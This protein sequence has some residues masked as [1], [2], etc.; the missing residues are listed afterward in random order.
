M[1]TVTKDQLVKD[2]ISLGV[3]KGELLN[4]KASLK[5]IGYVEGGADTLIEALLTVVGSEGTIITDSFVSVFSL[6]RVIS[7]KNLI[8]DDSTE[9]YAGALA[10]AML[11]HPNV[12]RSQHPVQKFS[13]IGFRAKELMYDHD[14]ESYAYNVL[15]VLTE[16]DGR[17]LKIG[18][19]E[20]V[21]GVGTT[22]LA[23]GL[24]KYKQKR[25]IRGVN[26]KNKMGD[27]TVFE[28]NWAGGCGKGFNNFIP[29]YEEN[30]AII[31]K[32]KI[33]LADSKITDMKMTLDIEKK[34]LKTD[35]T[36]FM[37]DDSDCIDCR[38]SW[39]FSNDN[40]ISFSLRNLMKLR[41]KLVYKAWEVLIRG[42]YYPENS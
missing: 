35:P 24:L 7:D 41:I 14:H 19:D 10:N 6:S 30:V 33:G 1:N 36:Y 11:R 39:K 17:N 13:A 9:S 25:L 23:I 3:R 29:L 26:F 32:G 34:K 22:H 37:C 8:S 15:K 40:I 38:L 12:V 31:N 21:V 20:K 28:R 4:V 27:V 42:K 2:L 5:S 18:T 16:S